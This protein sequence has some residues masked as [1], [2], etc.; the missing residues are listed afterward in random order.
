MGQPL[1]PQAVS[2]VTPEVRSRVSQ[3]ASIKIYN[4]LTKQKEVFEPIHPE[5]VGIY[6]CGPTVY[7]KSHIGHMVG[8]VIFD[9]VKRYLS[10]NGYHVT[11]V[12][13]ITD[14]DDKIINQ[15]KAENCSIEDL[16]RRITADYQKHLASLGVEVDHFPHAT[17]YIDAMQKMIATLIEKGHAYPA[18]GDVYFDVT[19]FNEYGKLSNR[20][21]DELLAG[22]RKEVSD[23]KKS[24]A[25]FALWKGAKPASPLGKVPGGRADQAGISNVR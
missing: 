12:V 4:T 13:N 9:T 3:S 2:V 18:S 15:A 14:I 10:Y 21:I 20:R 16:S 5:K 11:F 7:S 6:L 8:P 19:S 17:Q 24:A 23:I 25:D 1:A 22:A